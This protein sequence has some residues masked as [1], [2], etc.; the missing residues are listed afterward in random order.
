MIDLLMKR[1]TPKLLIIA[2]MA[3][4]LIP[5]GQG[6][7]ASNLHAEAL[8]N[9]GLPDLS[10]DN[11]GLLNPDLHLPSVTHFWPTELEM[12]SMM[13][14]G[15][16]SAES[17]FSY[18]FITAG[19]ASTIADDYENLRSEAS[20]QAEVIF[21]QGLYFGFA[22]MVILLNLVCFFL[23]EERVFLYYFLALTGIT[24]TLLFSD[25]LFT[26][27]GMEQALNPKAIQATL[28]LAAMGCS[29][30][31]AS[32][33][34]NL[35]EFFP[36]L[37]WIALVQFT[38]AGLFTIAAWF[39]SDPIFAHLSNLVVFGM[40]S[41]YFLC[42]VMLFSRKNYA[43]F[44]V[45]AYAIPLLFAVD[46]FVLRNLGIEFLFTEA[47][48]VKAAALVEMLVMTYAIVYRMQAIKEE[49]ILRQTE[50]RIFL[51]QQEAL[52]SRQKTEKLIEDVYLENLIMH[53]DLDGFEIK[54]L[55]YIS[56]GKD[57]TKIARKLKVTETDI[58][59]MTKEL[60]HKLEIS[61]HIK[62]DYRIVE[63]QPDYI[64]N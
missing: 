62:E 56:E 41:C 13:P 58:E 7:F 24:A 26:L 40:M 64:Y 25:G 31:F 51:K 21:R 60:Y 22:F 57:N 34:L 5:F 33:Y 39:T 48:H 17:V 2:L 10:T 50:M 53:Y 55:Q 45:I 11:N 42:G 52:T 14:G 20:A 54:L 15:N 46:F 16:T 44:Y 3:L 29:A 9:T 36:K 37:K 30:L 61:E 27:F 12:N 28:L 1:T 49:N 38:V 59:E 35:H 43:K 23:F 32:A 8:L 4:T 63:S 19:S 18:N 47:I 6:S